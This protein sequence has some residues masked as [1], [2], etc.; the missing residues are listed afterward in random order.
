M[1]GYTDDNNPFGDSNLL[2]P[3][4]WGKKKEKEKF[5]DKREENS[6]IARLKL[7]TEIESVRKRRIDREN[8]L[9]EIERLRDEEQRLR[10]V[11]DFIF[12]LS[13]SR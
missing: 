12:A 13:H 2:Q 5:S 3:F 1:L 10:E 4:V 7:I 8:E 6:E 9:A 11:N